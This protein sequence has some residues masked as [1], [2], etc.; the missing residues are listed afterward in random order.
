VGQIHV[1]IT[2]RNTRE[3]VLA[4]LGHLTPGP[5]HTLDTEALVDTG[6]LH[7]VLPHALADQLALVRLRVQ[8]VTMADGRDGDYPQTEPVTIELLGRSF[9]LSALVMGATVLLGAMVL[10]GLDLA[11]DPARQVLMPNLGTW[12]QPRFR[13]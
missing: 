2:L 6:A 7:L 8:A 9:A 5:V 3:E 4:Q 1:P 11:V 13:A 10:E 12:D